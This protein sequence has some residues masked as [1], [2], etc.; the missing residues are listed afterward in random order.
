MNM[1]LASQ[2]DFQLFTM[3]VELKG[4]AM[5][6]ASQENPLIISEARKDAY[7]SKQIPKSPLNCWN[8]EGGKKQVFL[9]N[10]ILG[11]LKAVFLIS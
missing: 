3:H 1:T 5:I 2:T 6:F 4:L 11:A 10:F 7:K 9:T 8:Y